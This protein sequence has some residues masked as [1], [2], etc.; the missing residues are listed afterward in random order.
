MRSSGTRSHKSAFKAMGD[1]NL[2]RKLRMFLF[3]QYFRLSR[4]MTLGVRALVRNTEGQILLIRH[5][6]TVG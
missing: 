1:T 3:R 4:P 2:V 5:T 6:Y